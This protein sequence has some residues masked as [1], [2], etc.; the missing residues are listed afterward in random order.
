MCNQK[1]LETLT[2][3]VLRDLFRDVKD[4]MAQRFDHEREK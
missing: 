1:D 3:D 4:E 2:D